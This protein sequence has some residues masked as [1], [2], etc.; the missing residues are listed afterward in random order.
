MILLTIDTIDLMLWMA[1]LFM[2]AAFAF[3]ICLKVIDK[4]KYYYHKIS[5]FIN[6]PR[7]LVSDKNLKFITLFAAIA[8]CDGWASPE[9]IEFVKNHI[10]LSPQFIKHKNLSIMIFEE[11][12]KEINVRF[13]G[14]RMAKVPFFVIDRKNTWGENVTE[15]VS[16]ITFQLLSK[17]LQQYTDRMEFMD[18]LFQMAYSQNGVSDV[19]V[20]LLRE[21]AQSLYIRSWDYTSLLYKY[22]Y[23]KDEQKKQQKEERTE[24]KNHTEREGKEHQGREE[25]RFKNVAKNRITEA[26]QLLE[27]SENADEQEIKSAYRRLVKKYHPDTL[28]ANVSEKEKEDAT[29][30]FRSI[31]EAYEFLLSLEEMREKIL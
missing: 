11:E 14:Y 31:Q 6:N 12:V 10:F 5:N 13:L 3:I 7:I 25:T 27:I 18:V 9:E 16:D 30:R 8:K 17:H 20:D 22:E 2:V 23:I 15:N 29:A 28:S 26:H 4:I 21:V 24:K 19:E 1:F